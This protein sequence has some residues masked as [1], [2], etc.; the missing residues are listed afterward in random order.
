VSH[1]ILV[2]IV[3]PAYNAE[4]T[5]DE[6]LRS[7]RSQTHRALDIV[8]VDDGSTD[9]T[10][11]IADRHAQQDARVRVLRQSNAGVA[12][13]RNA[14]W[15]T[16]PAN[17][18]SFID[19]DD[20]WS[21][22]KV[23]LQLA[24]LLGAGPR[25]GMAF[26]WTA[27]IDARSSITSL[28]GDKSGEGDVLR[29][30]LT[31]NFIG[32]GS[33]VMVTRQAL[34]DVGGFDS[35]LRAGGGEGCE[36]WLFNCSVA[37]K[38]HAVGVGEHL[39]GYRLLQ[40]SMSA[41]RPQMLRSHLLMTRQILQRRPDLRPWAESGVRSFAVWMLRDAM[42]S[43]SAAQWWAMWRLLLADHSAIAW[44]VML[45]DMLLDPVR[46][47]RNRLRQT[48]RGRSSGGTLRPGQHFLGDGA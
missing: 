23:A 25:V 5:L 30:L 16:T 34:I 19:A 42:H 10:G 15:Q 46:T 29:D 43:S 39:V 31:G 35:S 14:G 45:G 40:Q 7:V 18:V 13:A 2:G 4:A 6:T 20:L 41:N 47:L 27:R 33:N 48:Y 44:R 9:G 22:H 36:D 11:A 3:V 24:A 37:E 1:D 12:A 38:Y 32:S 8:V 17:Y 26:C 21:P 28:F